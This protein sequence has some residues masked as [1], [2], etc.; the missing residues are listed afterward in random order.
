MPLTD[1]P[2]A[3]ARVRVPS[4]ARR[5]P[6]SVS[7]SVLTRNWSPCAVSA[8]LP[9]PSVTVSDQLPNAVAAFPVQDS[10]AADRARATASA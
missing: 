5:H 9:A 7:A 8:I 6:A 10:I 4:R 3:R 1:S 2:A